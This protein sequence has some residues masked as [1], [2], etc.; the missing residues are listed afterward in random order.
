VLLAVKDTY[1]ASRCQEL[2]CDAEDL[3]ISITNSVG[4]KIY[5]CCVYIP[6]GDNNAFASFV[7]NLYTLENI[8]SE[9]AVVMVGDFNLPA[10]RWIN[11]KN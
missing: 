6:P 9:R 5:I 4:S 8:F 1:E 7:N 11:T 2:E 3:W 10:V